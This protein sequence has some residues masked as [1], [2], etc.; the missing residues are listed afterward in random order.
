MVDKARSRRQHGAG[1]GLALADR[2]ARVHGCE[3]VF[4]SGKGEGTKVS[5]TLKYEQKEKETEDGD[6][7]EE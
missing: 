3:L 7:E 2:I 5:F 4:Q 1:L 6:E